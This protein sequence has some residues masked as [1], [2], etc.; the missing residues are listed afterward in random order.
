MSS[1]EES[2]HGAL[3]WPLVGGIFVLT[4]SWHTVSAGAREKLRR[5]GVERE[6]A[7]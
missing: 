2:L 4:L 1:P 3:L 6:G 5:C 7:R